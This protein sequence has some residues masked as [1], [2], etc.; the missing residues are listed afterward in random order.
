M[1]ESVPNLVAH[2]QKNSL[3]EYNPTLNVKLVKGLPKPSQV[4]RQKDQW[5]KLLIYHIVHVHA[6]VR[7]NAI[8]NDFENDNISNM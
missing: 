8:T 5:A 3:A 1:F 6:I 7:K 2:Y 4:S